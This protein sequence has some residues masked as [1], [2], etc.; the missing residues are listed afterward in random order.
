MLTRLS[1]RHHQSEIYLSLLIEF[2]SVSNL[3]YHRSKSLNANDRKN[4]MSLV[5]QSIRTVTNND[6]NNLKWGTKR[7]SKSKVRDL[8][9][10]LSATRKQ[11]K[12]GTYNHPF[13]LLKRYIQLCVTIIPNFTMILTWNSQCLKHVAR[14]VLFNLLKSNYGLRYHF[15]PHI[16]NL[17]TTSKH[18]L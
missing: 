5:P 6:L 17:L 12:K 10:L 2:L 14:L 8:R 16:S 4:C 3:Q 1:L 11:L 13:S 18:Q 15:N 7:D 9:M